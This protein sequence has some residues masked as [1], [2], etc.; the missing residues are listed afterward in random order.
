M[1]LYFL[2]FFLILNLSCAE[3]T[4]QAELP[5][6]IA[7]AT[8][9]KEIKQPD[10][11]DINNPNDI[12]GDGFSDRVDLIESSNPD[13]GQDHRLHMEVS[14][15]G[16]DGNFTSYKASGDTF[17]HERVGQNVEIRNRSIFLTR[18]IYSPMGGGTEVFQFRVQNNELVLIGRES[19]EN[20]QTPE[21]L[22]TVR[23]ESINYL[24]R[25]KKTWTKGKNGRKW[26][27]A[28]YNLELQLI[29]FE[30]FNYESLRF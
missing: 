3:K 28:T 12:N 5:A 4:R 7:A 10:R 16:A 27:D 11:I 6:T 22:D 19:T 17:W 20:E 2:L 24:T 29:K 13:G 8:D 21:G 15:G 9:L 14:L 1:K 18:S 23:G 30:E 25:Q 26:Q